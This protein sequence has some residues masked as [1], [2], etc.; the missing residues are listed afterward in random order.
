MRPTEALRLRADRLFGLHRVLQM[1]SV[2]LEDATRLL[3]AMTERTYASGAVLALR[4]R[5]LDAA[6]F[7]LD[8]EVA[9]TSARGA[10][11]QARANDN[12]G[13]VELLSEDPDG[14]DIRCV[15]DATVLEIEKS[16]FLRMAAEDFGM[17]ETIQRAFASSLVRAI[18]FGRT[19]HRSVPTW[20]TCP[21]GYVERMLFL[22]ELSAL[23]DSGIATLAELAQMGTETTIDGGVLLPAGQTLD[24]LYL[25]TSGTLAHG[26]TEL[27][28]GDTFGWLQSMAREP[29]SDDL[30]ATGA[31]SVLVFSL[32]AMLE[33]LEEDVPF[34]LA[35]MRRLAQEILALT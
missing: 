27:V 13:F 12:A 24:G 14:L 6:F 7:V 15:A 26:D 22:R 5:P 16:D 28:P 31:A 8:G 21:V 30:V 18:P 25:V 29:L 23:Y 4:G 34:A 3:S 1:T 2:S 35:S 19:I 9:A 11:V 20:T 33:L 10:V 17:M 32:E